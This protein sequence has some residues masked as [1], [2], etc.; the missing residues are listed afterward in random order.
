MDK[1]PAYRW[2]DAHQLASFL[3]HAGP[4]I[5]EALEPRMAAV[6]EEGEEM[7]DLAHLLDV[8]GRLVLAE[9]ANLDEKD[10]EKQ[11]HAADAAYAR[12]LLR[13]DAM[14]VLRSRVQE[15][16]KWLRSHVDP[17]LTRQLLDFQGRTPRSNE[18]LEDL[19]TAMVRHLPL[20]PP[21]ETPAGK[22]D[23]S[24][25]ADY[26]R[27]PLAQVSGLLG[28]ID[29]YTEKRILGTQ[30][31][32]E[33]MKSFDRLFRRIARIG[34][35]FCHLGGIEREAR[36]MV[37]KGGRPGVKIPKPRGPINVA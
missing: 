9:E 36:K 2:R 11:D 23:P 29:G 1:M 4:R 14:P 34:W 28:E 16:R 18:G 22:I 6:L 26:L 19:A 17:K 7:P 30:K 25:W 35:I 24:G 27:E 10:N 12:V 13:R 33:A 21:I 8:L 5:A 32:S 37:Y 3:R 15:V 20:L 31:K